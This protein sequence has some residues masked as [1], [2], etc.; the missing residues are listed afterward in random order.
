MKK[1][2]DAQ[3]ATKALFTA[4][5]S[6][7]PIKEKPAVKKAK[8]NKYK[9]SLAVDDDLNGFIK[10]MAWQSHKSIARY[11]NELIR[12]DKEKYLKEGGKLDPYF[13][14]VGDDK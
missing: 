14:N 4:P 7:E 2:F 9:Y 13:E 10:Q 12:A 3:E 5:G 6:T 8:K 1:N 11:I